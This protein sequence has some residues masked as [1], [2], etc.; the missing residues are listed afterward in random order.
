[1][2]ATITRYPRFLSWNCSRCGCTCKYLHDAFVSLIDNAQ[3]N[4]RFC[5]FNSLFKKILI[6]YD[7][8]KVFFMRKHT[9][10]F[11][12]GPRT[13]LIEN[14]FRQNWLQ[15]LYFIVYVMSIK[16]AT[17]PT[18]ANKLFDF[19]RQSIKFYIYSFYNI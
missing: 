4:S 6:Q 8:A 16:K 13:I 11:V 14:G 10:E 3:S 18:S 5:A 17:L 1:M 12:K 2:R 7:F 15:L 9:I 19:Y